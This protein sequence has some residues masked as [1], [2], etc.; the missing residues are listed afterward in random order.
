[1]K[2]LFW[3]LPISLAIALVLGGCR[4][5]TIPA[6]LREG[7]KSFVKIVVGIALI[8]LALQVLLWLIPPLS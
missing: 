5:E 8:C 4:G 3:L 6:I 7:T 2:E 1:M